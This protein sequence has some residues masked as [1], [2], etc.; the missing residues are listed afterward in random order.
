VRWRT[1]VTADPDA[2]QRHWQLT[3]PAVA[4]GGEVSLRGLPPLVVVEVLCGVQQ[5]HRHRPS[6]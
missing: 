3:Q 2:D 4:Q 1:T 6:A 5:R